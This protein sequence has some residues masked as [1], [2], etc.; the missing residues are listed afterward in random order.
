MR[1]GMLLLQLVVCAHAKQYHAGS[2]FGFAKPAEAAIQTVSETSAVK[3]LVLKEIALAASSISVLPVRMKV[4]GDLIHDVQL[5]VSLIF[6]QYKVAAGISSFHSE[7]I[8]VYM[9]RMYGDG[10]L[11]GYAAKSHERACNS[12]RDSEGLLYAS[13]IGAVL[14][15]KTVQVTGG[16]S[17]FNVVYDPKSVGLYGIVTSRCHLTPGVPDLYLNGAVEI[18]DKLRVDKLAIGGVAGL[19][20]FTLGC[21][22]CG[23]LANADS[24]RGM[25]V[26]PGGVYYH[27]SQGKH[28]MSA[29][30]LG[31]FTLLLLWVGAVCGWQYAQRLTKESRSPKSLPIKERYTFI[32]A[33]IGVLV[34]SLLSIVLDCMAKK[35]DGGSTATVQTATGA[36]RR[37]SGMEQQR[38]EGGYDIDPQ[39]YGPAAPRLSPYPTS[40]GGGMSPHYADSPTNFGDCT[41]AETFQ[42]MGHMA[43]HAGGDV[44]SAS[45]I[46]PMSPGGNRYV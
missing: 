34:G 13:Q 44:R 28:G 2:L 3:T 7:R 25:Q 27:S 20:L 12:D 38:E 1:L 24:H 23:K 41:Q 32:G 22:F 16:E 21:V 33:A 11:Y 46:S 9:V 31:L 19:T 15:H 39:R 40:P 36:Y 18:M 37:G 17:T 26:H 6:S 42:H 14:D 43:M 35:E 10:T 8:H 5:R 29:K 4:V 30:T 45:P